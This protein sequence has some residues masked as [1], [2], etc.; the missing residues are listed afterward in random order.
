MIRNSPRAW[1]EECATAVKEFG[2]RQCQIIVYF[3]IVRTT[4]FCLLFTL[5]LNTLLLQVITT[6]V[7]VGCHTIYHKDL[8][9]L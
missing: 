8:G 2:L 4:E 5:K 7:S 9:N 3:D 6:A 1:F